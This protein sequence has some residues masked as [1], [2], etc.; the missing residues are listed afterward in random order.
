MFLKAVDDCAHGDGGVL[1]NRTGSFF[2]PEHIDNTCFLFR[3]CTLLSA[4]RCIARWLYSPV[5]NSRF[6]N[7][8]PFLLPL[9]DV[10]VPEHLHTW[11]CWP[12]RI[13]KFS[14]ILVKQSLHSSKIV[15]LLYIYIRYTWNSLKR[16][17][18]Y[19]ISFVRTQQISSQSVR[20]RQDPFSA[21]ISARDDDWSWKTIKSSIHKFRCVT[22]IILGAVVSK[23]SRG[24]SGGGFREVYGISSR[25]TVR[26][27]AIAFAFDFATLRSSCARHS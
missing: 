16:I 11:P 7:L 4:K 21:M 12:A 9:P 13:S 15:V 8:L 17:P 2:L 27:P 25:P 20:T 24:I 3:R 14:C 23:R 22:G 18:F 6:S 26:P 5:V 10:F 1:D 19:K